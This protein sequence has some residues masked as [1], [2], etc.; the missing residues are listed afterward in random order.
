MLATVTIFL[1]F[2]A[3][4]NAFWGPAVWRSRVIV[5]AGSSAVSACVVTDMHDSL[6]DKFG[7]HIAG[8]QA[9]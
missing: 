1:E 5:S 4:A 6:I 2:F 8:P 3:V 7:S 9:M